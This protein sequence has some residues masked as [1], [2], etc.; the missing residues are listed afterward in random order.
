MP[1]RTARV[2]MSYKRNVEPDQ[3][4][5]REMVAGLSSSG[6]AVFIDE[7]LTVGQAWARE[8]EAQVRQSD[9]LVVFLTAESSH[10]EMVRGEIEIARRQ[11]ACGTGLASCRCGLPSTDLCRIRSTHTSTASNTRFGMTPSDTSRLLQ[12]LLAA[13]AGEQPASDAGSPAGSSHGFPT[14]APLRGAPAGAGRCARRRRSLVFAASGGCHRARGD[15]TGWSDA[16][17]QRPAADGQELAAHANDQSGVG[18]R[19]EGGAARFPVDRRKDESRSPTCSSGGSRPPLRNN[20]SF[21]TASMSC[22]T[23]DTRIRRTAR[24][25]SSARF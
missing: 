17:P 8:I 9:F 18:S 12:E 1:S 10:S 23:R 5:A 25:T 6:C 24:V 19:Q 11:S 14:P 13:M 20:S 16:D 22:G 2:F 15:P 4:L 21:P 7:R 3:T